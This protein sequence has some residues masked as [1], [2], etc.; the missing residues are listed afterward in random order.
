MTRPVPLDRV[1]ALADRL[2]AGERTA[3][4]SALLDAVIDRFAIDR[5][6]FSN[7]L[8]WSVSAGPRGVDTARFSYAF[9]R[10][11]SDR[12]QLSQLVVAWGEKLG[13]SA[14]AAVRG[15]VRAARRPIVQQILVGIARG[16]GEPTRVKLYLQFRDD[17]GTAALALARDVIGLRSPTTSDALP[18][19]LLGL[20]VGDGGLSGAKLYFVKARLADEVR[21][22]PLEPFAARI[23]DALLIHRIEGPDDERAAAPTEIDFALTGRAPSLDELAG[24]TG[25]C[26]AAAECLTGLGR[27]FQLR[28]RRISL[29]LGGAP[30]TNVYYVLDEQEEGA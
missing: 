19:H 23:D 25:A 10:W 11:S 4:E 7:V 3:R 5:R 15:L 28:S 18:L 17:A 8:E 22:T 12:A 13:D 14:A 24:T 30:K 20:D 2:F 27:E 29:S 16:R 26:A 21:G 1:R 6:S 9:P